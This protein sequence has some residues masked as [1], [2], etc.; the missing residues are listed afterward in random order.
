MM[1]LD[2]ELEKFYEIFPWPEDIHSE[3]G[4]KRYIKALVQFKKL[5]EHSWISS[6]LSLKDHL[7]VIDIC[8]GS[9]VGGIAFTKILKESGKDVELTIVDLRET[10]LKKA[11]EFSKFELGFNALTLKMDVLKLYELNRTYDVCLMYGLS[12]PHFNPFQMCI[13]LASVSK[14]LTSDGVFIMNESDRIYTVFFIRGYQH[15]LPEISKEKIVISLHKSY[16]RLTGTF[17]RLIINMLSKDVTE[18]NF[19]FWGLAELMAIT[20]LLFSDVDFVSDEERPYE[21]FILAHKPRKNINVND[22]INLPMVLR[23]VMK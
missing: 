7:R 17:K 19:Y 13:L 4:A 10:A 21:G 22:L 14:I 9:G 12:A 18:M 2:K 3:E 6:L 8:G 15:V 20:W 11:E 16:D 1:M 5:I 23:N